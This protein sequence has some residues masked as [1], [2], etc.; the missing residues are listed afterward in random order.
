M[1]EK[2]R[3]VK[4][5]YRGVCRGCGAP[6]SARNGKGDALQVAADRAASKHLGDFPAT[7][8]KQ[9]RT[10]IPPD[11]R[12]FDD[13]AMREFGDE[14]VRRNCVRGTCIRAR[15]WLRDLKP[16]SACVRERRWLTATVA[17]RA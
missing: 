1:G 14:R 12:T 7:S 15:A 11:G 9:A 17:I 10:P 13:T 8:A 2:A 6:T 16:S 5:R 4:A 3:E